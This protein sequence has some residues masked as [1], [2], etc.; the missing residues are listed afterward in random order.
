MFLLIYV[1]YKYIKYL[2][3]T[4]ILYITGEI[5]ESH[6]PLP[7]IQEL[8][9]H[10]EDDIIGAVALQCNIP[11]HHGMTADIVLDMFEKMHSGSVQELIKVFHQ[12]ASPKLE[13][14]CRTY[15]KDNNM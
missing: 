11:Y 2:F 13:R 5:I 6:I 10:M 14:I 12:I 3:Y 9:P 4:I 8:L 15:M 1:V 7:L